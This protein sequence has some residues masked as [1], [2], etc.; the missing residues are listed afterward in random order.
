MAAMSKGRNFSLYLQTYQV[1]FR[2]NLL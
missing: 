2:Q 1:R